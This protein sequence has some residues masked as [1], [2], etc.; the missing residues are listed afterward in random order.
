MSLPKEPR[1]KMI[2]LMYLVLTAL[3]ALNVSSEIL[4]AFKIVRT[5]L[6]ISTSVST[7]KTED[8]FK[9]F[10]AKMKDPASQEMATIW[11]KK[12]QDA[13]VLADAA[14]K[15]IAQM[16]ADLIAE[17]KSDPK[18][19]A[20]KEDDLEAATRLFITGNEEKKTKPRGKDMYNTLVDFKTKLLAI[21]TGIAAEFSKSLPLVLPASYGEGAHDWSNKFFHMTPT[22]AGLTI[23]SKFQNDIRNS[24]TQ[25]VE[26]CHKKIGEVIFT[27]DAFKVI[28]NSSASYMMPGDEFTI[29]A[30]IGAMSKS[31]EPTVTVDGQAATKAVDE[32]G[33]FNGSYEVKLKAP[34]AAGDYSKTVSVSYKDQK[35]G[36]IEN[37]TKIIK[38]T[39]GQPAGLTVSTDAT[40][41]FYSGGLEN[42]LSVTGSGG[43][44]QIQL[45]IDGPGITKTPLGKGKFNIVCSQTGVAVVKVTDLK[46][47]ATQTFNIPIKKVPDPVALLGGK[48]GGSPFTVAQ[49]RAQGGVQAKLKDFIFEGYTFKVSS[50]AM[51]FTG[52]GFDGGAP[53]I[54]EV[55]GNAFNAEVRKLMGKCE[56]GTTVVIG[57]IRV[58][59]QIGNV[60]DLDGNLTFVLE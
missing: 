20:F 59:D 38:Y 36:K 50:F 22:I 55:T 11:N 17:A 14:Y 2:N 47:K 10:A 9:S 19:T 13:H 53:G 32:T 43:S 54:V 52:P 58:A 23:L 29:Q 41:V 4:N 6:D 24:E 25:V 60:R 33:Q 46:S 21:D 1:Q 57:N 51:Y 30:G 45:D 26:F 27:Y 18:D 42:P 48:P 3:L 34:E 31:A 16:Q 12:A 15:F 37:T 40:R 44:E 8:L 5:S 35:T 39:V 28:A 56:P 49:F 7:K